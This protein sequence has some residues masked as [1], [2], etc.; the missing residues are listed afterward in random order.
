MLKNAPIPEPVLKVVRRLRERGFEAYLVGGGVR[1]LLRGVT[2]K[3]YDVATSARPEQVVAS[4]KK[5]IPTGIQHGTVTVLESS[6]HVEVTTFR[7]EAEYADGRR[8]SAVEFHSDVEADLSRRDFTIN[9][10]AYDPASGTLVDPFGGQADLEKKLVR[11]VGDP[12]AR[13]SED[14]LRPLRA[15][16]FS[17]VL[18]FSLDPPTEAAIPATVPVF[19]KVAMER[20]REEFLKLL[21]CERARGGLSL[22]DRSG[23]LA[24]FLPELVATH[25]V[26]QDERYEADVFGHSL[27]AVEASPPSIELRLSALLHDIAKPRTATPRP[28]G[29]NTFPGHDRLGAEMATT[30]LTRLKLPS[31][32][33]QAV[34]TLVR[35]HCLEGPM[36]DAQL[37][38]LA[39]RVGPQ[40]FGAL[41][42]LTLANRQAYAPHADVGET[43]ALQERS[44]R[45]LKAR[46]A[47]STQELAL[48]GKDIMR[49]LG[50]GPGALVGEATR[51]LL[52]QV[53][54]NPD[55]N[56][57]AQLTQVLQKWAASRGG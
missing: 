50:V 33:V 18:G 49:V 2:P 4:F 3:D 23:L 36:S 6:H 45:L 43:L 54:E 42:E 37:R 17:A 24:V 47:L 13:F 41:F 35:H 16:R 30:I 57:V 48:D 44:Q 10:I 21:T 15:V 40:N 11:C 19:R 7:S 27:A 52:D 28:G 1:D 26:M 56:T 55:L 31:R 9:A 46:P 51:F 25:G 29:G 53:L 12:V 22:L 5:V 34:S 8:P 39:A 14:G 32:V 38:R 20:V